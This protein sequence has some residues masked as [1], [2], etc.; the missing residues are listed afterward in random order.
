MAYP[1]QTK[2]GKIVNIVE[3]AVIHGGKLVEVFTDEDGVKYTRD[4]VS[5][6]APHILYPIEDSLDLAENMVAA[7]VQGAE[8]ILSNV[9]EVADEVGLG[10]SVDGA[11]EQGESLIE[12][13][14]DKLDEAID[15]AQ[16]VVEE[17]ED[18]LGVQNDQ[19][20]DGVEDSTA[21]E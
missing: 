1:A 17:V 10:D 2:S 14:G 15:A 3:K 19:A 12:K 20:S 7:G 11:I 9:K 18:A 6:H 4:L 13:V 16:Q 21:A 8:A 5:N